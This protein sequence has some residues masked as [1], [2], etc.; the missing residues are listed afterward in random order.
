MIKKKKKK[1]KLKT[2]KMREKAKPSCHKVD[3][4]LRSACNERKREGKAH[5]VVRNTWD[6][7]LC[8]HVI[9][10]LPLKSN[11]LLSY[12]STKPPHRQFKMLISCVRFEINCQQNIVRAQIWFHFGFHSEKNLKISRGGGGDFFFFIDKMPTILLS[13]R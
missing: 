11:N 9:L 12:V 10:A 6:P 1:I 7:F 13:H 4:F 3:E 8:I 5:F 2:V